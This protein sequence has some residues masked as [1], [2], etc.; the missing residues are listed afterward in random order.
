MKAQAKFFRDGQAFYP[1]F[2]NDG[3]EVPGV[4]IVKTVSQKE[5]KVPVVPKMECKEYP[6]KFCDPP[7]EFRLPTVPQN[8]MSVFRDV[9]RSPSRDHGR[10]GVPPFQ[11]Y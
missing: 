6:K 1:V 2:S 8:E 4:H 7:S 10:A 11:P 5:K 3:S 9:E